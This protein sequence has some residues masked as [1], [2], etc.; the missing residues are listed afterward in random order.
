LSGANRP[1][2]VGSCLSLGRV[3]FQP[4]AAGRMPALV[5]SAHPTVS[6]GSALGSA[7][8]PSRWAVPWAV[9]TLPSPYHLS[10]SDTA[11]RGRV[12]LRVC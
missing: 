6:V 5:G 4:A 3:G 11:A 12:P 10:P 1:L 7:P 8:L 9:P 2:A